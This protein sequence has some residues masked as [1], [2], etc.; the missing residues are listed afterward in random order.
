M[1]FS[2]NA[3]PHLLSLSLALAPRDSWGY[4]LV[5]KG[6]W[7]TTIFNLFNLTLG[8]IVVFVP[9]NAIIRNMYMPIRRKHIPTFCY[10]PRGLF[11]PGLIDG[12]F[13]MLE[14]WTVCSVVSAAEALLGRTSSIKISCPDT[15]CR[16]DWL[17][18]V[19]RLKIPASSSS[20]MPEDPTLMGIRCMSSSCIQIFASESLTHEASSTCPVIVGEIVQAI[21]SHDPQRRVMFV[22]IIVSR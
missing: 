13:G 7:F 11:P 18:G 3:D 16:M 5:S 2:R 14:D 17:L 21:L 4:R 12:A 8:S 15:V 1:W 22:A 10:T 20:S 9:R 6:F 19:C